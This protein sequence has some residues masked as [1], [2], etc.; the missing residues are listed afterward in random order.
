MKNVKD[1]RKRIFGASIL[2]MMLVL[3]L[4]TAAMAATGTWDE[5]GSY[6]LIIQKQFDKGQLPKEVLEKA[7]EQTYRFHIQG[8]RLDADKNKIEIDE[9]VTIG[10]DSEDWVTE[11]AEDGIIRWKLSEKFCSNGPIHVSV[12]EITNDITLEV[13]GKEYNMGASRVEASDLYQE[14]PQVRD[15]NNNGKI[16]LSRP[17]TKTVFEGGQPKEVPVTTTSSFRIRSEWPWDEGTVAKPDSWE[18]YDKT[19]TLKPGAD[20]IELTGLSAGRYTIE[21]LSVSGYNIQLG[22]RDQEVKAGET[23]TFYINSKPGKLVITAGGTPD[24]G[25]I[26]YYVVE[27]TSHPEGAETFVDRVTDGVK[28]GETYTLDNLPRGEYEVTEYSISVPTAFEV[29]VPHTA[30]A[31][32]TLKFQKKYFGEAAA[33]YISFDVGGDYITDFKFGRLFDASDKGLSSKDTYDFGIRYRK[34]ADQEGQTTSTWKTPRLAN[35]KYS[36]TSPIYPR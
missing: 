24:D 23:G 21:D 12:T 1:R 19:V 31:P 25:A 2:L 6:S 15:L 8:Y 36:F 30:S 10:P 11:E 16:V 20:P 34:T 18:A 29:T 28:S 14:S 35:T 13:D 26:H 32:K 9:Y 33:R 17:A 27:R 22:A 7:K 3:A 4:G 5:K